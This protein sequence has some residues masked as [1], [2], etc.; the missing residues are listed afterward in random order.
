MAPTETR[1]PVGDVS[2]TR[3]SCLFMLLLAIALIFSMTGV[4]ALLY[5]GIGEWLRISIDGL[6]SLFGYAQLKVNRSD[7]PY[8]AAFLCFAT[9]VLTDFARRAEGTMRYVA[10][11]ILRSQWF[12]IFGCGAFFVVIVG[13]VILMGSGMIHVRRNGDESY[14]VVGFS[15]VLLPLA[16]YF[17]VLAWISFRLMMGNPWRIEWLKEK[18]HLQ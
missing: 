14:P 18:Y 3:A 13:E 10:A 16:C 7:I 6:R 11:L 1:C 5:S 17:V 8:I 15:F 2:P 12:R 9:L 4:G